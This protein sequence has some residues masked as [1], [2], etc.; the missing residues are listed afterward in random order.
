MVQNLLV[1]TILTI[2][3]ADWLLHG[4]EAARYYSTYG[5]KYRPLWGDMEQPRNQYHKDTMQRLALPVG[6]AGAS[7]LESRR[8]RRRG[9]LH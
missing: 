2:A 9:L 8:R 5:L 6:R 3:T 7:S 1:S 4:G